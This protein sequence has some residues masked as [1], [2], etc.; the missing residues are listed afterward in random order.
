[1]KGLKKKVVNGKTYYYREQ[2]YRNYEWQRD[3]LEQRIQERECLKCSIKFKSTHKHNRIC[4]ECK[5]RNDSIWTG[6]AI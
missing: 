2:D 6:N 5:G 3:N 4:K 1:M